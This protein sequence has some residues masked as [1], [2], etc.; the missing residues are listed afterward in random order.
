MQGVECGE[1]SEFSPVVVI[2]TA[3]CDMEE[4]ETEETE[5]S[6]RNQGEARVAL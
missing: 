2:D 3:G 5:E 4:D 6:R 1:Q